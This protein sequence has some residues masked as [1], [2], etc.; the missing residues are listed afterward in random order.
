MKF[1]VADEVLKRLEDVCFGVVVARGV[2]NK[3]RQPAIAALLAESVGSVRGRFAG[4]D[5]RNDAQVALYRQAFSKLG[6]NPNKF[7]SSVEAM[8]RR[9]VKGG[10]L[11]AI[12]SVVD[13]GNAISL[14][15]IIPL[16]A[17]DLKSSLEDIEVR[18]SRPED[19]FIPFGTDEPEQL[20]PGEVVYARG[21]QIKTRRW[22]WRQSEIGKITENSTDIFFPLDG[23]AANRTVVLAAR[24]ELAGRLAELFGC[25]VSTGLVDRACPSFEL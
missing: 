13:L 3:T 2:D 6:C 20:E 24:D 19:R 1:K 7:P 18:F 21:S 9:I 5:V 11:P 15:Y 14:K 4:A 10:D 12:N 16:G 17:H 22:I 23:F 8:L 25:A